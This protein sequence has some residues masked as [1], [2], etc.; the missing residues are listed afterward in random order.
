V[1]A[2]SKKCNICLRCNIHKGRRVLS[3]P[4]LLE[5]SYR[6]VSKKEFEIETEFSFKIL[7]QI[8]A[9]GILDYDKASISKIVDD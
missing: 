4:I 3:K 7:F 5:I 8:F 1:E 9:E 2:N 6:K